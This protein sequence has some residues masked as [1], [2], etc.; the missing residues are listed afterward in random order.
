MNNCMGA[1]VRFNKVIC[2][3][4]ALILILDV[5]HFNAFWKASDRFFSPTD[6]AK[7]IRRVNKPFDHLSAPIN[8]YRHTSV[9][10]QFSHRPGIRSALYRSRL[11]N[12]LPRGC[13]LF[14]S[15]FFNN[16]GSANSELKMDEIIGFKLWSLPAFCDHAHMHSRSLCHFYPKVTKV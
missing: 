4:P 6:L 1:R 11:Q 8:E 13:P 15:E 7:Y 2:G 12:R 3:A 9:L 14:L 5:F 16:V 10:A